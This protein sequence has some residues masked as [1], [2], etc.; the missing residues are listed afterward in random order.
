MERNRRYRN[1]VQQLARHSDCHR[2]T[3]KPKYILIGTFGY[4]YPEWKGVFYPKNLARKDFLSYYATKFNAVEPLQEKGVLS[5]VLFQ[6]PQSFHYTR[7]NRFYLEALLKEFDGFPTVVEFRH[8]EW[9]KD[10][11]N[12]PQV[13]YQY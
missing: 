12:V 2:G 9:I 10:S 11:G 5:S 8:V 4:D 13:V 7:N 1:S 6:L 3:G